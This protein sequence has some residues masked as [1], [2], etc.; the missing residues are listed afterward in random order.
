MVAATVLGDVDRGH[1]EVF[2]HTA[3]DTLGA[4]AW[5]LFI[6]GMLLASVGLLR[7]AGSLPLIVSQPERRGRARAWLAAFV[8]W[9]LLAAFM[10][11]IFALGLAARLEGQPKPKWGVSVALGLI[12][13]GFAALA[14]GALRAARR[15]RLPSSEADG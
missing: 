4:I 10:T 8:V 12:T 1:H 9:T 13:L 5:A 7:Y 2:S 15:R 11:C 14:R 6:G 3:Y